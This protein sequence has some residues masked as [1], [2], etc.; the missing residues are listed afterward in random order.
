L[1]RPNRGDA[2]NRAEQCSNLLIHEHS[3]QYSDR[4]SFIAATG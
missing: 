2:G 3:P 4:S 1:R